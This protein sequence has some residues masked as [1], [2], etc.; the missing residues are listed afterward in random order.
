VTGERWSVPQWARDDYLKPFGAPDYFDAAGADHHIFAA[1]LG[2]DGELI[3]F[4]GIIYWSDGFENINDPTYDKY[5]YNETVEGSGW[6]NHDIGPGS[7]YFPDQGQSGPWCWMPTGGSETICG[8]GLP[9]N[10]H[11]STFAVWQAV[12]YHAPLPP[13]YDR[14]IYVPVIF[15]STP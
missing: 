3:R 2:E 15:G 13:E 11:V 12:P 8:G 14:A 1:V 7:N 5:V 4:K 10:N 9:Y 6:I